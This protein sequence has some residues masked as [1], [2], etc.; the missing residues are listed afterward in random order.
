MK[1][2]KI[3][4][5]LSQLNPSEFKRFDRF[6]HSAY[7][8]QHE[9]TIHF[10]DLIK[11]NYPSF[12]SP[13]ITHENLFSLLYPN[14]T[15]DDGKMR[16]LR[17]YLLQLLLK[18]FA[19]SEI[20]E[21]ELALQQLQVRALLNKGVARYLPRILQET[22]DLYQKI[23]I[24][25]IETLQLSCELE[26][27]KL[28]Y[29]NLYE[30]RW[31][32]RDFSQIHLAL[33]IFF[34][35]KKLKYASAVFS[36]Q[37]IF[38]TDESLLN[39]LEEILEYCEKSFTLLPLITL[40][41]YHSVCILMG[42]EAASHYRQ[43]YELL[44]KEITSLK[45]EEIINAYTILLN[46]NN[47]QYRSGNEGSLREMLTVYR[48]MIDKDLLFQ[49]GLPS[50]NYYKN[51]VT[52]A[53][54][55]QEY[56]WTENFIKTCLERLEEPYRLEA[57][58]YN[59]GHLLFYRGNYKEAMQHLQQAEF[60]DPFYRIGYNMLLLKIYFETGETEP[61]LALC[62]S[63][64]TY[65]HRKSEMSE[66]RRLPYLNFVKYIKQLFLYKLEKKGNPVKIKQELGSSES[67]VEKGWLSMKAEAL[68]AGTYV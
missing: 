32:S 50:V 48:S 8:T 58:N 51:V 67:L 61:F 25:D 2:T 38:N 12:D 34:V 66:S 60:L 49:G 16:T 11:E 59:M 4:Q 41:Y 45:G 68:T 40:Y 23:A 29:G 39:F 10:F 63:F 24:K 6:V 9:K 18:F 20:E 17:K 37:T 36:Y 30:D 15:F 26:E 3:I 55:L 21:N 19:I 65:L 13:E 52:I 28:E 5:L 1:E 14:E 35:T 47:K 57:F 42:R 46:Y 43:L 44:E 54:Q 53:L 62:I 31:N 7:F 33:D 56:D 22:E 27:L 64:R